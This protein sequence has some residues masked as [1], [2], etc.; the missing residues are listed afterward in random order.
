MDKGKNKSQPPDDRDTLLSEIEALKRQI[1]R[2]KLEK[3]ILERTVEIIKKI[4]AS[5][6]KI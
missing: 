2:L 5:I 1:K 3:D 6:Q 4:R